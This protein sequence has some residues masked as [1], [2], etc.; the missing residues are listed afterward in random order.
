MWDYWYVDCISWT[1]GVPEICSRQREGCWH[2]CY[3]WS[4]AGLLISPGFWQMS[5]NMPAYRVSIA[6]QFAYSLLLCFIHV[7]RPVPPVHPKQPLLYRFLRGKTGVAGILTFTHVAT[8]KVSLCFSLR[9]RAYKAATRGLTFFT[10]LG[11]GWHRYSGARDEI[12]LL[13]QGCHHSEC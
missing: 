10:S 8:S 13:F 6:A 11:F 2:E 1:W 4:E 5:M 3:S 12:Y 7:T 9:F